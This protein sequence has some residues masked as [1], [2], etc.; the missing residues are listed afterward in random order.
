LEECIVTGA[1]R[2]RPDS[3]D[4]PPGLLELD[5]EPIVARSI[6]LLREAGISHITIAAGYGARQYVDFAEHQRGVAVA[7]NDKYATT[8]SM[9]S[10]AMAL[11]RVQRDV[12]VVESDVIYE[13]RALY[14]ILESTAPD[15]T[16]LSG[17]TGSGHG[18]WVQAVDG[19]L[20]TMSRRRD[21]LGEV[22]GEF[23]G[24][25]RLSAAA[26]TA[27]FHAFEG[28]VESH[29]HAVMAYECDGLVAV[30]RL[31]PITTIF[32]PDLKWGTF[33]DERTLERVARFVWPAVVPKARVQ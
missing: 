8:G 9:A 7:V 4:I 29:D 21:E 13:K 19:R 16:I 3:D 33:D 14:A 17:K 1:T 31:F 28:F 10:L 2:L 24:I 30:A 18:V 22:T 27:M 20:H 5:G 26:G 12:L 15:S 11:D 32:L 23:V 25:T 6:R